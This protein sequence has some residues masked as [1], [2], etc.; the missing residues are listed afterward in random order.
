MPWPFAQNPVEIRQNLCYTEFNRFCGSAAAAPRFA[1]HALKQARVQNTKF[2][3]AQE[4][5]DERK[6]EAE[7]GESRHAED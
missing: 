4:R 1:R 6:S 3:Y 5:A 2:S 7:K